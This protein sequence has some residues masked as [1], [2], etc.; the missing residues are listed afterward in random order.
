[1]SKDAASGDFA[2]L[3]PV[4]ELAVIVA[5]AGLRS[6]PVFEPPPALR[7]Y[8]GFTHRVP[9]PALRAARSVLDSDA[10]YRARVRLVATEELVGSA[11]M[12]FLDRLEGWESLIAGEDPQKTDETDEPATD[13]RLARRLEGAEDAL[14]RSE[15]L[16]QELER[17]LADQTGARHAA[18]RLSQELQ[19]EVD[20][21]RVALRAAEEVAETGRIERTRTAGELDALRLDHGEQLIR[22]AQLEAEQDASAGVHEALRSAVAAVA[23]VHAAMLIWR[24]TPAGRVRES[25]VRPASGAQTPNA[26]PTPSRAER[27][28][29]RQLETSGRIA[30]RPPGY[31]LDESVAAAT[32]LL[33]YPGVLVLIDGYNVAKWRWDAGVAPEQL[34]DRL[35]A[36][37]SDLSARAGAE[38]H[39]VFDGQGATA[40]SSKPRSGVRVTFSDADQEADDHLLELIDAAPTHQ[41]VVVVSSDQRVREGARQRGATALSSPAFIATW[42]SAGLLG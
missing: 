42:S 31:L 36:V 2:A 10:D 5:Q 3:H 41:P 24:D 35:I 25:A 11:G 16:R 34:R 29:R 12:A 13:R 38:M 26:T 4:L 21:L 6:K 7:R 14:R 33:R 1:M 20:E 19:R 39:I 30:L 8:L 37:V 32:Y 23:D 27:A 15:V 40:R 17:A 28:K 18:D 22:I 9:P